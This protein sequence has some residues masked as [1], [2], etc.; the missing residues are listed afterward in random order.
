MALPFLLH[1]SAGK[2]TIR[3]IKEISGGAFMHL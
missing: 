2:Y 1:I 3:E